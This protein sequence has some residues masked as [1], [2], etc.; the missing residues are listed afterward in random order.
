MSVAQISALATCW[1]LAGSYL[2]TSDSL[3]AEP[4]GAADPKQ[5]ANATASTEAEMKPY[6]DVIANTTAQF[7]MV[8]IPGGKFTH[9]KP[10]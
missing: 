6:T 9:G 1:L 8:P 2:L 10:G 5:V 3:R 4:A 7:K